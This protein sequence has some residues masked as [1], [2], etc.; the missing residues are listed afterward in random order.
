MW[1]IITKHKNRYKVF[2]AV[3]M[4]NVH[5]Y[6][7]L[8]NL[9]K[10]MCMAKC[11]NSENDTVKFPPRV[12]SDS[13]PVQLRLWRHL[14]SLLACSCGEILKGQRTSPGYWCANMLLKHIKIRLQSS[15]HF[16]I[17]LT[18]FLQRLGSRR[19]KRARGVFVAW[20]RLFWN[21]TSF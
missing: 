7:L 13:F 2:Q 17:L 10:K 21:L 19:C 12:F 15:F 11:N 16:S 1:Q 9:G 4:Y 8:K 6:F 14:F 5:P 3:P 20:L 18:W